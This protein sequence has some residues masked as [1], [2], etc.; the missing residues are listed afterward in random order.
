MNDDIEQNHTKSYWKERQDRW[1]MAKSGEE[2][3]IKVICNLFAKILDVPRNNI[4]Y[5]RLDNIWFESCDINNHEYEWVKGAPDFVIKIFLP[6][7][8]YISVEIKL[9]SQE[10]RKTTSGG[11]TKNGS[12]IPNYGCSSYYLDVVPVYKNMN[13]FVSK[14]DRKY[15]SFVIAFV[16][17]DF[18][19]VNFISLS[20]INKIIKG[21]WNNDGK[22]IDI[23]IYGE[24]YGRDTYLIPK[25]AT[26]K[27][28][29]LTGEQLRNAL[30]DDYPKPQE[31]NM[32]NTMD[33]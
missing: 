12:I 22:N 17:D 23:C 3:A 7:K 24:G 14:T 26:T 28:G 10:Y 32:D 25:D 2:K 11:I 4:K 33:M 5:K 9:K 27:G 19:E 30:L 15:P 31:T 6:E 13:D 1:G 29:K 20:M 21:G 16:K 18:S 8:K